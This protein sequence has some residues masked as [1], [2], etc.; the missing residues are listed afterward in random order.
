MQNKKIFVVLLLGF[1]PLVWGKT[2]RLETSASPALGFFGDALGGGIV[3]TLD[4]PLL[5]LWNIDWPIKT[6]GILFAEMSG[7]T[8][9]SFWNTGLGVGVAGYYSLPNLSAFTLEGGLDFIPSVYGFEF[10]VGQTRGT[11]NGFGVILAPYV[12]GK[13]L[14]TRSWGMRMDIAYHAGIYDSFFGYI[15]FSMGVTYAF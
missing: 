14:F 13:Y 10:K 4:Y 11:Q 15:L 1:A 12:A 7:N 9:S 5:H 8:N 6:R 2:P 3:V